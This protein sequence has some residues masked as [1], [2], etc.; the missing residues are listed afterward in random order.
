MKVPVSPE[1]SELVST[2]PVL[3]CGK[4][5]RLP[6]G[7]ESL[8]LPLACLEATLFGGGMPPKAWYDSI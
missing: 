7:R 4:S 8:E 6:I 1:P 5:R 2:F 3:W